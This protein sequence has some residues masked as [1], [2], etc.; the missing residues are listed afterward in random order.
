[1]AHSHQNTLLSRLGFSD[2]DRSTPMHTLACEYLCKPEVRKKVASVL[3]WGQP[4]EQPADVVTPKHTDPD[5]T[6][7]W[8]I[9]SG[10][11]TETPI[12]N[13][14]FYIGFVDVTLG[15]LLQRWVPRKSSEV[16]DTQKVEEKTKCRWEPCEDCQRLRSQTGWRRYA[17]KTSCEA[18]WC[19]ENVSCCTPESLPIIEPDGS[20]YHT[21]IV[22][23]HTHTGDKYTY[24]ERQ[25]SIEVLIEVKSKQC[26][27]SDIVKQ[28]KLYREYVSVEAAVVATCYPVSQSTKDMLKREGIHHIFLGAGFEAYCAERR[29]EQPVS[30]EGL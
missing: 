15:I 21:R 9:K 6:A 20:R 13:G 7:Y 2:P 24:E 17:G 12:M 11:R 1:M 10:A 27:P 28:V 30:E 19:S 5:S 3:G 26:D 25:H 8:A 16:Y 14:K 18:A 22:E 29:A 23:K 4:I